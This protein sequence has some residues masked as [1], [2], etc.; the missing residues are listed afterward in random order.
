[1]RVKYVSG[2]NRPSRSS[3]FEPGEFLEYRIEMWRAQVMSGARTLA[4]DRLAA[5]QSAS[6][7]RFAARGAGQEAASAHADR[8]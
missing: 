6:V 7:Q 2:G 1:M 8:I 3:E 5:F 4:L